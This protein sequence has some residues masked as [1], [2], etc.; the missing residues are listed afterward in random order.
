MATSYS[1]AGQALGFGA[2]VNGGGAPVET[3]EE[4]RKRIAAITAAQTKI[5]QSL[6][7]A[8]QALFGGYATALGG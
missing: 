5:S 4:K 6:S 7:P 2:A 8:G 1:P 3:E